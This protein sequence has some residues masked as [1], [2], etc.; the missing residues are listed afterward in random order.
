[1]GRRKLTPEERKIARVA[2]EKKRYV[3]L[4]HFRDSPELLRS[5][6]DYLEKHK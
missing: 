6:A 5:A 1:M 3:S 2:L 4:G